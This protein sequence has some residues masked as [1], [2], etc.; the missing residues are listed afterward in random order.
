[1]HVFSVCAQLSQ[2]N[3]TKTEATGDASLDATLMCLE[4]KCLY[5]GVHDFGEFH[6][7]L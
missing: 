7:P 5:K 3:F 1:M 6:I 4:S 2:V